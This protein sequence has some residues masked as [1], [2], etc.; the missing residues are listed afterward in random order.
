MI[1]SLVY[2]VQKY[3]T[4]FDLFISHH[5]ACSTR[6][7]T[8]FLEFGCPIM[9]PCYAIGSCYYPANTPLDNVNKIYAKS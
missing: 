7:Q 8:K 5:Q 4:C 3:A 2:Y 1:V 9:D 6:T